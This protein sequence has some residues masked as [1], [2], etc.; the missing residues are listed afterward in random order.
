MVTCAISAGVHA[1]LVPEHLQSEPREGA[2]FIVAAVLLLAVAGGVSARPDVARLAGIAAVLFA[3]L[4]CAYVATR[5][6]G[7]PWLAPDRESVDALGVVTNVVELAGLALAL[8]RLLVPH[9]R[10]RER[11]IPQ[12][13]PR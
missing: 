2:A 10:P 11:R 7:I 6:S 9:G 5:T 1:G 3:G 4:V 13:V 12:E 8:G